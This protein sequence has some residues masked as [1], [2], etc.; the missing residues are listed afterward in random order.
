VE[1]CVS[2]VAGSCSKRAIG[3]GHT[4]VLLHHA[5]SI[6]QNMSVVVELQ[7]ILRSMCQ[8]IKRRRS[9]MLRRKVVL[10]LVDHARGGEMAEGRRVLVES[11]R[12][13]C[14]SVVSG[15][16]HSYTS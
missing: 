15:L 6:W 16:G 11:G 12:H 2:V 8:S 7:R 10:V 9:H 3:V 4:V 14:P 5:L 1:H 13:H